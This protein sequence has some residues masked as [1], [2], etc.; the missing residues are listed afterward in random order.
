[1]PEGFSPSRRSGKPCVLALSCSLA[2][3]ALGRP[4]AER[5]QAFVTSY[6]P[7]M[8]EALNEFEHG[9]D[10]LEHAPGETDLAVAT[11][12]A[13]GRVS[14]EMRHGVGRK[15]ALANSARSPMPGPS[16]RAASPG[17][18][19]WR[20]RS[21]PRSAI[22]SL[23]SRP[24]ETGL[25]HPPRPAAFT[26]PAKCPLEHAAGRLSLVLPASART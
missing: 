10:L 22:S 4:R 12:A 13:G 8:F 19:T 26:P 17:W 23:R 20:A 11:I 6:L 21:P 1:M 7:R 16:C 24:P 2:P 15:S 18:P 25:A 3:E 5:D 14:I 9:I